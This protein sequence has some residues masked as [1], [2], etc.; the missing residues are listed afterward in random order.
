M[1][2]L[3]QIIAVA[4]DRC[5]QSPP[6]RRSAPGGHSRSAKHE[7]PLTRKFADRIAAAGSLWR[8][9]HST[10]R[11]AVSSCRPDRSTSPARR[12][13]YGG[14]PGRCSP[15]GSAPAMQYLFIWPGRR[16]ADSAADSRSGHPAGTVRLSSNYTIADLRPVGTPSFRLLRPGGDGGDTPAQGAG[17]GEAQ[18]RCARNSTVGCAC[19]SAGTAD[20]GIAT[21]ALPWKA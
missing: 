14:S 12:P 5:L 3:L 15:R 17:R 10:C 9:R 18:G 16:E 13:D 20:V 21:K 19:C 1:A 11:C 8:V 6:A 7:L 4:K 2:A